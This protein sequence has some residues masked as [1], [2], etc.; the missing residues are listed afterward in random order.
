MAIK[1]IAFKNIKVYKNV[2][3]DNIPET[4]LVILCG[5]NSAGKSAFSEMLM[6]FLTCNFANKAK[7]DKYIRKGADEASVDIIFH[8]GNRVILRLFR[9]PKQPSFYEFYNNE[10]KKTVFQ[11]ND[12]MTK[13]LLMRIF[14]IHE[15]N[16]ESLNFHKTL[17]SKLICITETPLESFRML[18]SSLTDVDVE[19]AIE[20]LDA[21]ETS[22]RQECS[23]LENQIKGLEVVLQ[24]E[25]EDIEVLERNVAIYTKA[26][27]LQK[28][29]YFCNLVREE[30]LPDV[31]IP[32]YS[33]LELKPLLDIKVSV[34]KEININLGFAKYLQLASTRVSVAKPIDDVVDNMQAKLRDVEQLEKGVCP[35]CLKPLS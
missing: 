34:V 24:S 12:Q 7:R 16:N 5:P 35:S 6:D 13:L 9:Q 15:Y 29:N 4:G 10:G 30:A 27:K 23:A 20:K 18:K 8:N 11:V 3:I 31:N 14:N 2:R 19:Y 33:I 26:E 25:I 1:S 22:L 32:S 17:V 21:K 28:L